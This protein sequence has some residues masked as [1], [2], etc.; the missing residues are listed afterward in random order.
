MMLLILK[1]LVPEATGTAHQNRIPA[2]LF[3]LNVVQFTLVDAAHGFWWAAVVGL[4]ILGGLWLLSRGGDDAYR[5]D[6]RPA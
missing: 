5:F 3:V 4:G 1:G 2:L 6:R